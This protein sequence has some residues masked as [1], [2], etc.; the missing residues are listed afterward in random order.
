MSFGSFCLL[1]LVAFVCGTLGSLISGLTF[2]MWL[3][4]VIVGMAGAFLGTW[5]TH[6]LHIPDWLTVMDVPMFWSVLGAT[7]LLTL[8]V[9]AI[10]LR[11][12]RG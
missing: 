8:M 4:H 10:Q 5:I 11:R 9:L 2:K 12:R 6:E 1:L 3:T 7:F